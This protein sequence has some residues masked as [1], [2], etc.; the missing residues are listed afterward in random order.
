MVGNSYDGIHFLLTDPFV[1]DLI[2]AP[3]LGQD[4]II[5]NSE[6]IAKELLENRSLNTSGR[7]YFI[8]SEL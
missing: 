8:T 1:G 7:P 6:K 2:Y 3:V 4:I 5:I